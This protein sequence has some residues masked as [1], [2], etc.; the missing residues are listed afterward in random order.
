MSIATILGLAVL[1]LVCLIV[2]FSCLVVAKRADE[3]MAD[4]ERDDLDRLRRM[5]GAA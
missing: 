1:V 5:K 4:I 2:V 3:V